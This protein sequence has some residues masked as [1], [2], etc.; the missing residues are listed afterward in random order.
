MSNNMNLTRSTYNFDYTNIP[1]EDIRY[2]GIHKIFINVYNKIV[3]L[4]NYQ[5]I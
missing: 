4:R 5:G 3:D 1:R 2:F